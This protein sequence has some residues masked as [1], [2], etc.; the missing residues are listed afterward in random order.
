M[1]AGASAE[2]PPVRFGEIIVVGG[3]CYG[4]FYA[5]QLAKAAERGKV[6]CERVTIVDRNPACRARTELGPGGR[7]RFVTAEWTAFFD[8]RLGGTA[9]A[10]DAPDAIVPSPLMPHLMFEWL[11]RRARRR[12][13]DR[14]VTP[15]PADEPLGTPYDVLAPDGVRYVSWAD[16]MCPVH[17]IEPLVCP[18]IR[19]PRTWEMRDALEGLVTRMRRARP[20]AGPVVLHCRHRVHGVGMFDVAEVQAGDAAIAAAGANGGPVDVVVGTV[21]SC[22]GAVGVVRLGTVAAR[23]AVIL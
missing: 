19:A 2:T 10:P 8:E 6:V 1:G 12:W 4:T 23:S 3:G 14:P 17:C 21:S 7:R 11:L 9:G 18:V 15:A 22:H 20:A 5:G 16:W 13:P